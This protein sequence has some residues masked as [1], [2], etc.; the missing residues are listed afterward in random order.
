MYLFSRMPAVFLKPH[1]GLATI[2]QILKF[3][4]HM[5]GMAAFL[6][7]LPFLL[8]AAL[9]YGISSMTAEDVGM[10]KAILVVLGLLHSS[11]GSLSFAIS[12]AATGHGR[13]LLTEA[14]PR[15][16]PRKK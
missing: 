6:L 2:M 9:L 8:V 16:T 7:F 4:A 15:T 13:S 10:L 3:L 5:L 1:N 11:C 14:K 12:V